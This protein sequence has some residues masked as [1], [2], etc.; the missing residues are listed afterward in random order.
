M[1]NQAEVYQLFGGIDRMPGI[2]GPRIGRW[3]AWPMAKMQ[4]L[5]YLMHAPSSGSEREGTSL[6]RKAS[7]KLPAYAAAWTWRRPNGAARAGGIGMLYAPRLHRFR[8]GCLRDFIFGELLAGAGLQHPVVPLRHQLAA[9]P[10][11]AVN[12]T[13]DLAPSHA[14]GEQL[15]LVLM[16]D[17]RLRRTAAALNTQL[18]RTYIPLAA[19]TRG[20]KILLALALFEAKRR[21]FRQLFTRL[22]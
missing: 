21:I 16:L 6:L 10:S 4:L 22:G 15:A 13:I 9:D 3:R 5:W 19:K 12:D 14:Q 2:M 8:D 7:R 20:R 1:L 18:G 11:A 17:P